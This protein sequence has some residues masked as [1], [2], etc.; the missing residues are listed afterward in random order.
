MSARAAIHLST[1]QRGN[2]IPR[3][4]VIRHPDGRA[5]VWVIE[6]EGDD[7]AVAERQVELGRA[8]DGRIHIV[9]GLATGERVVVRGNE[10]LRQGQQVR[11][12]NGSS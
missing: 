4:A 5:T 1:G 11:V 12:T 8:F 3:D 7:L 10:S 6:G 9:D 2:T